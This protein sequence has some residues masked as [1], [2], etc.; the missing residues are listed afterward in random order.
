MGLLGV[1]ILAK[2]VSLIEAINPFIEELTRKGFRISAQIIT[3][4]LKKAGE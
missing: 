1:L 4:A 2:N 3:K